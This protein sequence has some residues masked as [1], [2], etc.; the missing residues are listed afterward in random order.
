MLEVID[1]KVVDERKY[2]LCR[3]DCGNEKWIRKDSVKSGKQKSCGCFREKKD[4]TNQRFG[5]LVVEEATAAR[6][7]G[8]AIV[9][10]CKC[11]CGNITYVGTGDL[12]KKAV[13]SCGCLAK[14]YH[15]EQ[16]KKIGKLNVERNVIENTHI[17]IIA[18]NKLQKN[19]TTGYKGV[20][21]DK[22][23]NKYIA[24]IYFKKTKYHLGTYK[25]AEKASEIYQIAKKKLHGEFLKWYENEYKAG[26]ISTE[27]K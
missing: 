5:R 18:N 4:I 20:I 2:W 12:I 22:A 9:W 6:E 21:F 24:V 14:E 27:E 11:D 23:R 3:C 8:G 16:G 15:V 13:R 10:K 26:K 25:T 19:N 17:G 1:E 7:K